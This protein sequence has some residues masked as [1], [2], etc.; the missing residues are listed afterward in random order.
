V[1]KI[2]LTCSICGEQ[3]PKK[4][5][6]AHEPRCRLARMVPGAR[7]HI[8]LNTRVVEVELICPS[9]VGGWLCRNI[10]TGRTVRVRSHR[11][12]RE[13]MAEGGTRPPIRRSQSPMPAAERVARAV[14]GIKTRREEARRTSGYRVVTYGGSTWFPSLRG[15]YAAARRVD[16]DNPNSG[17]HVVEVTTGKVVWRAAAESPTPHSKGAVVGGPAAE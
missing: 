13:W 6:Q 9:P 8:M 2:I 12:F 1:R 14:E 3:M 7:F 4:E 17:I 10:E 5:M 11:R 15:A 16:R